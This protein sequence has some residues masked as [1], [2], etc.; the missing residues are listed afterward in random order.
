[1]LMFHEELTLEQTLITNQL[2]LLSSFKFT[3]TLL[4]LLISYTLTLPIF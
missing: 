2:S 3:Y 4:I 1:M